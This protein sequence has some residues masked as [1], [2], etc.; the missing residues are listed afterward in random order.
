MI[1]FCFS[2][3]M[4]SSY[5]T[6]EHSGRVRRRAVFDDVVEGS[7]SNDDGDDQDDSDDSDDGEYDPMTEQQAGN[8][9]SSL[10]NAQICVLAHVSCLC[11]NVFSTVEHGGAFVF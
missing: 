5:Q 6:V 8:V 9:V 1:T 7:D 10:S 11:I 4:P 3:K 2:V